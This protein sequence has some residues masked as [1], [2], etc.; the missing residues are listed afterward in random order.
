M[1]ARMRSA[2]AYVVSCKSL[3]S[4]SLD[5]ALKI[6]KIANPTPSLFPKRKIL[7]GLLFLKNVNEIRP[8]NKFQR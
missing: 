8:K 7:R 3:T 1:P 6:N 4:K 2:T 5:K